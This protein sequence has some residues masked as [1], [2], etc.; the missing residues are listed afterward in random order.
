MLAIFVTLYRQM[1]IFLDFVVSPDTVK[2]ANE[3]KDK[4]GD[5]QDSI[6][7][8]PILD[9]PIDNGLLL[10]LVD[11]HV[12]PEEDE[13]HID[14]SNKDLMFMQRNTKIKYGKYI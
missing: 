4:L 1:A 6:R 11:R 2:P 9:V 8:K 3:V 13:E 5:I 12:E 7:D 10:L 14:E